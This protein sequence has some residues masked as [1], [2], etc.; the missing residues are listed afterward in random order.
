LTSIA[1]A[2]QVTTPTCE[3]GY[4]SENDA[5]GLI[6]SCEIEVLL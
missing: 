1:Q 4:F 2:I 3:L 6:R 5:A